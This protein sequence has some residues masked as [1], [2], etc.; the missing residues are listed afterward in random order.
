MY[1]RLTVE[2]NDKNIVALPLAIID[3][4]FNA[5]KLSESKQMLKEIR[6]QLFNKT[7]AYSADSIAHDNIVYF[8]EKIEELIDATHLLIQK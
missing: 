4:F 7:Y 5:H 1:S 3:N 2:Q 6:E 8:F